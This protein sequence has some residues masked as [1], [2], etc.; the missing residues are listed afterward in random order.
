MK[1]AVVQEMENGDAL[2]MSADVTW[3]WRALSLY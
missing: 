1:D 2:G 3:D